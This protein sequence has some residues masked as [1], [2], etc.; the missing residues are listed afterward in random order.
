MKFLKK[1]Y[2]YW[3]YSDYGFHLEEFDDP[4]ELLDLIASFPAHGFYITE[5][6]SYLPGLNLK[7]EEE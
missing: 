7:E 5:R 1:R 2:Q 3:W 6:V 4:K